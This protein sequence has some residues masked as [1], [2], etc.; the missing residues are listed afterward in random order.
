MNKLTAVADNSDS[1][2]NSIISSCNRALEGGPYTQA[3]VK[4]SVEEASSSIV[5]SEELH[6]NV[7]GLGLNSFTMLVSITVEN[8]IG[9]TTKHVQR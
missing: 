1:L 8:N 2:R 9:K 5:T 6:R 7:M 4:D 3:T